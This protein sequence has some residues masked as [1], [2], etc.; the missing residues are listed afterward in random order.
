MTTTYPKSNNPKDIYNYWLDASEL[1]EIAIPEAQLLQK[2]VEVNYESDPTACYWSSKFL[3]TNRKPE[4]PVY[5]TA[6]I[7]QDDKKVEVY[8]TPLNKN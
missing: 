7:Q 4:S 2:V 6:T 1:S 8:L 3:A 5:L